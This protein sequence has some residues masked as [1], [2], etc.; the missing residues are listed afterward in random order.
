M[1]EGMTERKE[2]G[3]EERKGGGGRKGGKEG[4]DIFLLVLSSSFR[5]PLSKPPH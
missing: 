1:K 3:K 5:N 2:G 4:V